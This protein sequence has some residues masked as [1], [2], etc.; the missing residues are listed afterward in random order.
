M[1]SSQISDAAIA[2]GEVGQDAPT[3][4]VGQGGERAIQ[5]PRR[6][7]NHLVK[8]ITRPFECAKIFLQ[9]ADE[10]RL[11]VRKRLCQTPIEQALPQTPLQ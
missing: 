11:I 1:G 2:A 10:S 6:I 3:G 7:F 8:Y 4:R 9:R 5:G